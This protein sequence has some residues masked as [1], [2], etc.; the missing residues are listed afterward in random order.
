MELMAEDVV[1]IITF[2]S[3]MTLIRLILPNLPNISNILSSDV[4]AFKPKTPR[5]FVFGGALT[6]PFALFRSGERFL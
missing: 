5:H 4:L 3:N 6:L 1:S 2:V